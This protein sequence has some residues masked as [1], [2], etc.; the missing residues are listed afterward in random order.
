MRKLKDKL[1]Y[2]MEHDDAHKFFSILIII[3][4]IILGLET[5]PGISTGYGHILDIIDK[6]I[7]CTFIAEIAL[8]LIGNGPKFFKNGWNV[9]DFIVIGGTVFTFDPTFSAFR[10]LRIL[11]L[12]EIMSLSKSMRVIVNAMIA[13]VP[14]MLHMAA[15]IALIFY[16]FAL[17][18]H[19]IFSVSNPDLFGTLGASMMTLLL[20]LLG[21][22][23]GDA[24][25][26]TMQTYEFSYIFFIL[27]AAV[28]SF[29]LLNLLFGIIVDAVQSAAENEVSTNTNTTDK[30]DKILAAISKID[31]HIKNIESKIQPL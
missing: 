5:V 10:T 1:G 25:H 17:V 7:N 15:V 16:I 31:K 19:D 18:G 24:I 29:T 27:Y 9:F 4:A 12:T 3:N 28:M 22:G 2:L 14:G 11:R 30:N 20:I 26:A 8:R 6:F 23:I 21:D 13:I